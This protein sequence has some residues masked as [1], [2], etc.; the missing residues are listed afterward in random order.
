MTFSLFIILSVIQNLVS[1]SAR[2]AVKPMGPPA[3]SPSPPT[4]VVKSTYGGNLFTDED[5]QYLKRY[6][7]YCQEQGLLL[8]L[9]EICERLAIKVCQIKIRFLAST[10]VANL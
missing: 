9:R 3:R 7:A 6:I 8:S 2:I 10:N 4:N 5:V 1:N